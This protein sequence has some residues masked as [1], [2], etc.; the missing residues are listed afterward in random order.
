MHLLCS[1]LEYVRMGSFVRFVVLFGIAM[2]TFQL[3]NNTDVFYYG[4]C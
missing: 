3:F 1:V 2:G 4:P